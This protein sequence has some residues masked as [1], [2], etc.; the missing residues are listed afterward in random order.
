MSFAF[1]HNPQMDPETW[2]LLKPIFLHGLS[3]FL[4][5]VLFM[6]FLVFRARSKITVSSRD[7]SEEKSQNTLYKKAQSYSVGFSS[8]NHILCLFN[9]FYCYKSGWL[10][11]KLATLLDLAAKTAA[12]GVVCVYLHAGFFNS[13]ERR[14]PFLFKVWCFLNHISSC[15]CF[16]VNII[17][18]EK[19]D[20]LPIQYLISDVV[21]A[22]VG[23]LFYYQGFL[24]KNEVENRTFEEPLLHG[25]TNV[26]KASESSKSEG[27]ET[28]SPYSTAGIFSLL[29][30]S[31]IGP[32]IAVGN[33]KILD[34]EDVP[35]LA[36]S[37][38]ALEVFPNF[39]N[40]IEVDCGIISRVNTL[41]L[42]KSVILSVSKE[43]LL[44][45]TCAIVSALA[46]YV[47]PYLIDTFVKYLNGRRKFENEGYFLV[48]AFFFAKLI[49]SMAQRQWFFSL[50]QAGIRIQALLVA[51]IYGKG[52][53][54]SSQSKQGQTSG[55]IIN[56]VTVDAERVGDSIWYIHDLWM[57]VLQVSLASFILYRNLGL[58]SIAALV[59]TVAVMLANVPLGKLQE[60][61]QEKLMKS[62]DERMKAT[63]EVLR[64][65]SILKL[66]GW[67]MK[68]L[69]KIIDL[70]KIE[71]GW[72]RRFVY[73]QAM[74]SFVF[75]ATPAFVSM[76][77]FGTCMLMG[78]PLESGKIL[79]ALATFRILQE[80]IYNLPD[81]ISMISQAKV[82][83]ERITSFLQ[84]DELQLGAV[85]RLPR[86]SSDMAIEVVDG[87][88]SWDLSSSDTTLKNINL[89]VFQGMKVAVCGTVGSG[90]SSLL[91]CILG[92]VPK[93]SG[94]LKVC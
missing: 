14:F 7:G 71:Q 68:F 80:P 81:T 67:E 44:T 39:R 43:I 60:N 79:S 11:E 87:N 86:G 25:N 63:S 46:S 76:V 24:G 30:Y 84:L 19:Y 23:L 85:E 55:E 27:D 70:R 74:T 2:F 21:S 31:W 62:K 69:S 58:A 75:W 26:S 29:S 53:T 17:L 34:L 77:T 90:K 22:A 50:R 88:F 37:D 59:S 66:Q 91:S 33:K 32:L 61:F 28:V 47:G 18:H 3:G 35:L 89:K 1:S 78:I 92:E 36:S 52:L 54:L 82:S 72:L 6:S 94:V 45:A 38:S 12:W 48:S 40:K 93:I 15:Y 5:L 10:D 16:A 41:K 49:E 64:N 9:Y 51:I 83:L 8:F 42:A 4:H 56:F 57:I 65:M 20:S 13:S 73:T